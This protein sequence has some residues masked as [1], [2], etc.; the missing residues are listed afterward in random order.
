[1]TLRTL[2]F[3]L[4]VTV[5]FIRHD[6]A[7]ALSNGWPVAS[8]SITSLKGWRLDP[9]GSGKIKWHNGMDIAVLPNTPVTPTGPG[10]VRF[11]GWNR[12]YGWLVVIDHHNGWFTMYGHN[13]SLAVTAG[14]EVTAETVI[15]YAGSTG[16]STGVHVHYEQRWYPEG[17]IPASAENKTLEPSERPAREIRPSNRDFEQNDGQTGEPELQGYN[18]G[19][20]MGVGGE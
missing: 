5:F 20:E 9:F 2:L 13:S 17:T 16:R 10:L 7:F 8:G 3:S 1:L 11:S 4:V 15:A 12:H 18:Q 14:Q 6:P 19:S